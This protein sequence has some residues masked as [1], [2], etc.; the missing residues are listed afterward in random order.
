M[1]QEKVKQDH[2]RFI[3][4]NTY[5]FVAVPKSIHTQESGFQKQSMRVLSDDNKNKDDLKKPKTAI[6]KTFLGSFKA[7]GASSSIIK[8][9]QSPRD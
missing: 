3:S 8:S 4:T 7:F 6:S 2:N 9:F 5:G 1:D